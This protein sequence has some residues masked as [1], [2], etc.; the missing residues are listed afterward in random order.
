LL[1]G[2]TPITT[3]LGAAPAA[4]ADTA[5][6]KSFA[7]AACGVGLHLLLIEPGGKKPVDMRSPRKKREDDGLAQDAARAQGRAD[8]DKVKSKG[9]VYLATNDATIICRYIDAYRKK[10]AD[11]YPDGVPVNF[12]V[13]VGPSNLIV[14]D[15]DTREQVEAF[16]RDSAAA[17]GMDPNLDIPPTVKSPGQR[18][19]DGN[20]A[21]SDG[22]HFYFTLDAPLPD[23]SGSLTAPGG[24]AVLWANR[25]VLIP[26]STRAEGEYRLTGQ[27]F[28]APEWLRA[29]VEAAVHVKALRSADAMAN[30]QLTSAV[31]QWAGTVSWDDLLAPAGWIPTARQDNCGCDIWT[32]PGDH[33]SPKSATAHDT[34][35]SL[36][37]YTPENA[38]LHIWTDNPGPELEAWIAARGSK[39]LSRLQTVAALEYG[40]NVGDAM[41]ELDVV[42]DDSGVLGFGKDLSADLG[43]SKANLDA[44]LDLPAKPEPPGGGGADPFVNAG[45][46]ALDTEDEP[47]DDDE[48]PVN[49]VPDIRP[50]REWRDFPPPEFIIDGLLE[51]RGFTAVIGPPGVGKSGI[52]LDMAACISLGRPWLGRRTM[53]QPVLYLPG[54][55]LSGAVQRLL[56]W[57]SAHD[58]DVGDDLLIGDSVIQVAAS[59]EAWSAV[60]SRMLEY[61]VGLVIIDTFARASVGLEENSATDVGKAIAKFDQVRKATG[62]G[63]MV[64]HHTRKDGGSGRGSSAL[65]G[66]LDTELLITEADWWDDDTQ[67]P[68]GRQLSV[69]VSKQK[70]AAAPEHGLPM[71]AVPYGES[72]I[73]TGP[74]GI[75]DDPLD[76]VHVAK[77]VIPETIVSVAIRIQEY[78]ERFPSQGLTR[79][80]LAYG[81]P[82]DDHTNKRR[83]AKTAWRMKINEAVDLGLRY[84]LIQTLTGTASGARYIPD[85]TTP[86]QARQRWAREN[87][88]D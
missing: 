48:R 70:N 28:P 73:M 37:R 69:N 25:Y 77:A 53:R 66:A 74:S 72:F 23:Y 38:P 29:K 79:A 71:L 8:W 1:G 63:V 65:N 41:R 43:I 26:P 81:I 11:D 15:C 36:G 44:P 61:R 35:C 27:D 60:V 57:E 40:G 18:D 49:G 64:V 34:A 80:E 52:V 87:M 30:V 85:V 12:G 21:H 13:S 6:L 31:D 19:E 32:A 10:Y 75:V 9:G 82:P 14:V 45:S 47:E 7:R 24:Y 16:L 86:D 2:V 68:P 67:P 84:Q 55:G 88:A 62:A 42:P 4:T 20:W 78:A 83:D 3:V 59:N 58:L 46:V 33:A 5:T 56:A 39:T 22:G 17:A 54:E 50:F 76:G 51:N